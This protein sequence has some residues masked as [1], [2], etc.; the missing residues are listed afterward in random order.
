MKELFT[1]AMRRKAIFIPEVAYVY[2]E[3]T[4]RQSTG[5]LAANLSKL[6]YGV[7]ENLLLALNRTNS[8]FQ[9]SVLEIV[10]ETMGVDKNWTPL[11]KGWDEP[12]GES[13][14][15]HIVTFFANV[16]HEEGTKLPC[17][18][19]I[20]AG[21]FP[22]ERYNGCPF[23]GT[24]FKFGSLENYKQG[25]DDKILKLFTIEDAEAFLADLLGS[26][27]ALDATQ[28]DSLNLLLQ[29]L[30]VPEI[31]V[32]MKETLM[33]VIDIHRQRGYPELAQNL[34]SSPTDIL[35]YLWYRH[36]G[37]VQLIEPKSVAQA[38]A[39]NSRHLNLLLDKAARAKLAAANELKLK[40][41]RTDCLIVAK[42]LNDLPLEIEKSCEMMHP[43]RNMWV[44]FIRALRLAEYS[45]RPGFER[46][47]E[48]MD[49]FYKQDY[50][51]WQAVVNENRLRYDAAITLQLL[52]QRPGLFARS[53]FANMLWFGTEKTIP[54]FEQIIDKVPARLV[55][56]LNM[57]AQKYFDKTEG[58]SVKPLGGAAKFIPANALLSF[59]SNDQL[60]E[61]KTAVENLCLLAVKKRFS[62]LKTDNRSIFIDPMLFKIPVSIGDRSE[63]VQDIPSAV[64]GTRF[65]VQ[66]NQLRLFMQWG[67]GL[68]AQHMDMDLSCM[69]AYQV[70]IEHC[71]FSSLT[72]TGCRHSGDIRSIPE[73]IG[74]AEYIEIDI[75]ALRTAGAQ[76]VTFTC[77][78]YSNGSLTPNMIVGWM[79]SLHPMKIS[80]TTGV[81]Y[82][83]S[84][85]QQ[86][87]RIVNKLTKGLVFGVLD[88]TKA[89]IIWLELPFSGQVV[90]QLDSRNVEALLKKLH[91]K[92]SIGNL[93]R[94]KA[95]AQGLKET[96]TPTADENYTVS[97][98]QNTAAVTKLLVD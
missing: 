76:Y 8:A 93:L 90:Q 17:A 40:Y 96:D 49:R 84:C 72:I 27:T 94:L 60:A 18:H 22:L 47:A 37:L 9:L 59:Y 4:I 81:A 65:A 44:R 5:L 13:L 2:P 91:S 75:P 54:A 6:G 61:M 85:V 7:S 73:K 71:S 24:A 80:E 36:T 88:V 21:T 74:T 46:L 16:F 30:P 20:P 34:F 83:P 53:L 79:N 39:K 64:M 97:W 55:F 31:K 78:A 19:I 41:S 57:H 12:T 38:K 11:V 45:K 67:N 35:R 62:A 32:G 82:D 15:D 63:T 87:V 89:E 1:V 48:L 86:Q 70:K 10:K 26:K 51:V 25:S 95:E 14:F 68:P 56:T 98:A 28:M 33:A 77:N 50:P 3:G 23:C 69:V 42:W 43:K 29:V 92:L 58:R 66:G 52:Q